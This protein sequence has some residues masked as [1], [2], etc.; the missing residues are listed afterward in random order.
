MKRSYMYITIGT[1]AVTVITV[2]A[3]VPLSSKKI[4]PLTNS[5]M[6]L[7]RKGVGKSKEFIKRPAPMD[8]TGSA[9]AIINAIEIDG[10]T[11]EEI[12][13]PAGAIRA[14][15]MRTGEIVWQKQVYTLKDETST[16]TPILFSEFI[17]D[18]TDKSNVYLQV[19]NELGDIF[20]VDPKTSD[21][22][23]LLSKHY[24]QVGPKLKS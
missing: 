6:I 19:T 2:F 5:D 12:R 18:E 17:K 10:I 3:Y 9:K 24:A 20:R 21:V 13:Y 16:S 1:A 4:I 23:P 15:D 8:P 7:V 14:T 22:T 11:Y